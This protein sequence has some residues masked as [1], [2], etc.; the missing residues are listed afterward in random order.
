MGPDLVC[1]MLAANV[2][3]TTNN[4]GDDNPRVRSGRNTMPLPESW[5][6]VIVLGGDARAMA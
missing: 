1:A 6:P 2:Y 4:D 3:G 5:E